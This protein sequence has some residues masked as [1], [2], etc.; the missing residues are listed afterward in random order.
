MKQAIE[1]NYEALSP[2]TQYGPAFRRAGLPRQA[3]PRIAA[4][5]CH[6]NRKN[7][8]SGSMTRS[9]MKLQ[10]SPF[11]PASGS[12]QRATSDWGRKEQ[13]CVGSGSV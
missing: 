3:K 13:H 12:T 7:D 10:F 6:Q 9:K 8:K 11:D 4:K 2:M 1:C 5:N